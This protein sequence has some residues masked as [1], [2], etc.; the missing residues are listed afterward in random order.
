MAE[1][2]NVSNQEN[3]TAK[4]ENGSAEVKTD[5]KPAEATTEEKTDKPKEEPSD[6]LLVKI[7]KQVEVCIFRL[8]TFFYCNA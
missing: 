1:T 2:E 6:E 8:K 3:E 7:R 5:V 4:E